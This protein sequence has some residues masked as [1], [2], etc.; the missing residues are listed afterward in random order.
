MN[1]KKNYILKKLCYALLS[2]TLLTGFILP[3]AQTFA[4]ESSNQIS[5]NIQNV[6]YLLSME[7]QGYL[8]VDKSDQ[9]IYI[10]DK[11]KNYVLSNLSDNQTAIFTDNSITIVPAIQTRAS[12]GVNKFVWT[13][14]GFDVYLNNNLCNTLVTGG[15]IGASLSAIIPDPSLSKAVGIA[16]GVSTALISHNN[17]GNGV[18]V[19]FLWSLGQPPIPHW[20]SSQ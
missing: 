4:A 2:S 3:S 13:W 17:H 16:L 6:D 18:I 1:T 19:A 9:K 8:I 5:E 10:T 14:K 12:G 15:A 11:Y 20:I 7:Q